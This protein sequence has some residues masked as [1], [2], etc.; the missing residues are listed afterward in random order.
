[1]QFDEEEIEYLESK[2]HIYKKQHQGHI[3]CMFK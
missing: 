1:L 3:C 2:T